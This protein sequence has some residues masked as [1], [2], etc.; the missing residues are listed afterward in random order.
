MPL[1]MPS[2][3]NLMMELLCLLSPRPQ[4]IDDLADDLGI[5]TNEAT[6]RLCKRL[7]KLGYGVELGD[8]RGFVAT[9]ARNIEAAWISLPDWQRTQQR[10]QK[11]WD[12][13]RNRQEV[14]TDDIA[15]GS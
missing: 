6:I 1:D 4:W 15:T 12:R 10:A 9:H 7:K 11:W 8:C 3:P 5:S 2:P 13:S 14:V